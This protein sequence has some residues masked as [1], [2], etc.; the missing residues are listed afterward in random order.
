MQGTPGDRPDITAR[1]FRRFVALLSLAA[2]GMVHRGLTA[3]L[4]AGT[5]VEGHVARTEFAFHLLRHGRLDGWFPTFGSG[6]RLF[7][8]YGPGLTIASGVVR[9]LTFGL[10]D[11]ARSLAIVGALSVVLVPWAVAWLSRE[12]G[13]SRTTAVIAGGLALF[14]SFPFGGGLAAIYQTGLIPQGLAVSIQVAALAGLLRVARTGSMRAMAGTAALVAGLLL[15][16]PISL[17]VLLV[18]GP[19]LVLVVARP[20]S[21][22]RVVRIGATGAWGAAMAGWWLLP[23]WHTRALRGGVSAWP[24]PPLPTRLTEIAH[25]RVLVPQA[26][27]IAAGFALAALAGEAVRSPAARRRLAVPLVAMAYLV[28]AHL[29]AGHAWGPL[30]LRIQFANRGLT[31]MAYL[32]LLP[33][34]AIVGEPI[35]RRPERERIA[36]AGAVVVVLA[37]ALAPLLHGPGLDPDQVA[38][39]PSADLAATARSLHRLVPP[40]GRQL[41]VDPSPF[42]DLGTDEAARWLAVASGRS[43]AHLY[44]PEATE[45]PAAG[46]LPGRAISTDTPADSLGR[47]RRTGITH[48]VVTTPDPANKLADALG[49][50]EVAHHGSL[51]IYAVEP[52]RDGPDVATLLQPDGDG[53]RPAGW[54]LAATLDHWDPERLDWSTRSALP[55]VV[56]AAVAG[57]PAWHLTV[58]GRAIAADTS[59]DG[60]VR[61]TLPAGV[62][63]VEL[64]FT[65]SRNDPVGIAI[66]LVALAGATAVLGPSA[67]TRAWAWA[68]GRGGR[69]S[70]RRAHGG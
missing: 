44:F 49:Y 62:H 23:A 22:G 12:L 27:A 9:L 13:S 24:T 7:A 57:D 14:V 60:L 51:A 19:P 43:T 48:V 2:L 11:T 20:R 54:S 30:E 35:A 38:P 68:R 42:V 50:R 32:L 6:Y 47:L 66:S 61:F 56:T 25:G 10:V 65:G 16:H 63:R 58:D 34:A 33:L 15:L 28:V 8:V 37:V 17:L 52:E 36:L 39:P 59:G 29:A 5:D 64:R 55:T 31:L 53:L 70:G 41:L 21:W 67:R 18:V 4:P 1:T 45:N 40:G 46:F 3:A 26:I 69:R